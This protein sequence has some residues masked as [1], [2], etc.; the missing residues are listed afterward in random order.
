MKH[1]IRSI[2]CSVLAVVMV[3]SLAP[4]ALSAAETGET[5]TLTTQLND[6]DKVVIY[7]PQSGMAL[8]EEDLSA[9]QVSYR[10]GVAVTVENDTITTGNSLIVW[11]VVAT[12]DGYQFVSDDGTTLSATGRKLLL[13][14]TDNKWTVEEAATEDCVYIQSTTVKGNQGDPAAIEWYAQNSEFSTYYYSSGSEDLFAMQLYTFSPDYCDEGADLNRDGD[15]N[16]ADVTTLLGYLSGAMEELEGY[17]LTGDG[18]ATIEDVTEMLNQLSVFTGGHKFVAGE[19]V[20]ATCEKEGYTAYTCTVCGKTVKKDVVE[21]LGHSIVSHSGQAATCDKAGY[22][23][24]ETCNRCDYTTYKALPA[25]GL[26]NYVNGTCSVC[27]AKQSASTS[28]TLSFATT[29]ARVSQDSDAQVWQAE[30]ITFTNE[31]G[32]STSD[33]RNFSKPVRCYAS[34]RIKVEFAGNMTKI[35]FNCNSINYA[36]ALQKSISGDGVTVTV[37]DK[38]VTVEFSACNSFT[39]EKLGSQVRIDSIEVYA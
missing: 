18:I 33:V 20:S 6:G 26:H 19:T 23:A 38:V 13:A 34:S 15:F 3:L 28:A 9:T 8:S 1:S 10:K 29:A 2:L 22:A 36:T 39:I 5:Y 30:G 35:V 27:G 16:I 31:K 21:A 24:Y 32:A 7:N 37:S 17:D 4:F 11:D 12:A 25:T 14:D